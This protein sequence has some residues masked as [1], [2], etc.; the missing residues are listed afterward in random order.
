LVRV[1]PAALAGGVIVICTVALPPTAR[2]PRLQI[3]G[4]VPL[5][6]PCDGVAEPNVT[7]AGSVSVR[8]TFVAGAGPLFLTVRT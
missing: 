3:T 7:P 8:T 4:L 5:H 6:V 2:L 1:V